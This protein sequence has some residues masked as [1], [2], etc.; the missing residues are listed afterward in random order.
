MKFTFKYTL[1]CTGIGPE[2][3]KHFHKN[4]L[5]EHFLAAVTLQETTCLR[6]F[7]LNEKINKIK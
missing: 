4:V 7:L 1:N 5:V 3:E 6:G 2:D